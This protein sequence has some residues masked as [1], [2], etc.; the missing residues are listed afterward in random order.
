MVLAAVELI[1]RRPTGRSV[2]FYIN[3]DREIDLGRERGA[4]PVVGNAAR[5]SRNS[6]KSPTNSSPSRA[7]RSG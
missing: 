4:R 2:H 3:P 6:A 7:A 1:D 5:T